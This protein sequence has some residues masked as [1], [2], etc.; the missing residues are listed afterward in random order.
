M[1]KTTPAQE[2]WAEKFITVIKVTDYPSAAE[3]DDQE[4]RLRAAL[5]AANFGQDE[6][7]DP[8]SNPKPAPQS[9]P[10]AGGP[11]H[12]HPEVKAPTPPPKANQ[13]ANGPNPQKSPAP[14]SP[15]QGKPQAP[16]TDQPGQGYQSAFPARLPPEPEG[17][18]KSTYNPPYKSALSPKT[19]YVAACHDGPVYDPLPLE[20]EEPSW[21]VTLFTHRAAPVAGGTCP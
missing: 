10:A 15:P 3:V 19:P 6:P 5:L 9:Q 20:L 18:Y 4:R 17:G 7:S 2:Q 1:P 8:P 11:E 14:K 13:P 16:L 21:T 12:K